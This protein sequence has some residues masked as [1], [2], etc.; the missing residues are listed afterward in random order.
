MRALGWLAAFALS[1]LAF[2]DPAFGQPAERQAACPSA[3]VLDDAPLRVRRGDAEAIAQ[4]RETAPC[5]H[6]ITFYFAA[7]SLFNAGERDEAV[8]W[9]YLGQLRGRTVAALDRNGA[10]PMAIDAL[11]YLVGQPLNEHAGGDLANWVAA[12]DW[13]L[14]FD[15]RNPMRRAGLKTLGR[16]M[17][18]SGQGPIGL[19]A[20]SV[21]QSRLDAARAEER[22]GLTA[23]RNEVAAL[24][25][26]EM[27]RLRRENGLAE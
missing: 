27:R 17:D 5:H 19:V 13:A 22:R 25:P 4:F 6:W 15:E 23:L 14:E 8:R 26:E 20:L 18:F 21:T 12:M 2:A 9:F 10:T 24:D 16:S 3:Q 1:T 7:E 11:Q